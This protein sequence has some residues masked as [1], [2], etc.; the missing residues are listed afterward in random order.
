VCCVVQFVTCLVHRG[1]MNHTCDVTHSYMQTA[2]VSMCCTVFA[3][4][5]SLL[6]YV[7]MCCSV[8]QCD[9]GCCSG[10]VTSIRMCRRRVCWVTQWGVRERHVPLRFLANCGARCCRCVAK[11]VAVHVAVRVAVCVA[12]Y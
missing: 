5:G 7:A 6:Q 10:D 2:R 4:F 8:L 9:A 3:V 1:H 11:C 12:E